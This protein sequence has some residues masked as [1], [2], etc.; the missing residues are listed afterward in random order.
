MRGDNGPS[1][2][3]EDDWAFFGGD[4]GALQQPDEHMAVHPDNWLALRAFDAVQTQWVLTPE[5]KKFALDYA[6]AEV[7]WRRLGM[8][9]KDDDFARIQTL[10]RVVREAV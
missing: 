2:E 3:L 8:D 6:R 5:G 1:K 10:E 4:T 7:A 9:P